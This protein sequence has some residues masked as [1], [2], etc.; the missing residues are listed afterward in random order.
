MAFAQ[1][2]ARRPIEGAVAT[3][4]VSDR[5]AFLRRTY[6]VLGFALVAFAAVTSGILV[7]AKDFSWQFSSLVLF[8]GGF[9]WILVLL[10]FVGITVWAQRLALSEASRAMQYVGLGI[11]VLAQSLLMQPILWLL[12][13]QFGDH[14]V[15]S[16]YSAETMSRHYA[17]HMNAHTTALVLQAALITLAIFVGLTAVAF[18][19]KKDFSFLRG[20]LSMSMF[21]LIGV[22]LSSVIFGFSLG[23]LFCG[24]AVLV[25]GGYILYQTSLIMARF[26]PSAHVGAAVMLF[27]TIATLF[28][29]VLQILMLFGRRD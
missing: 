26:P 15:I 8:S 11:A 9:S 27:T 24:L 14:V 29:L 17:M 5:V 28:R 13:M 22:A 10:L 18:T 23:A 2:A 12:L 25:I 3:L 4:G 21:G 19:S 1:T 16:S 20:I 7:Y 6:G